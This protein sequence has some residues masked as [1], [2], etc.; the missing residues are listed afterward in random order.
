MHNICVM[1][2]TC[3]ITC[4]YTYRRELLKSTNIKFEKFKNLKNYTKICPLKISCFT[5]HVQYMCMLTYY[6]VELIHSYMSMYLRYPFM[7]DRGAPLFQSVISTFFV[8]MFILFY[9]ALW[10]SEQRTVARR[11][12]PSRVCSCSWTN[13]GQ[14]YALGLFNGQISIMTK[15]PYC[16]LSNLSNHSNHNNHSNLSN[17]STLLT[18]CTCTSSQ[19]TVLWYCNN[20]YF[21][22]Y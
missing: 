8:W 14:Y 20:D 17:L 1:T 15:V 13:D 21:T 6:A 18:I 12:V 19:T 11:K 3:I 7:E 22:V 16:N 4:T 10:S 2:C 9:I 5:A